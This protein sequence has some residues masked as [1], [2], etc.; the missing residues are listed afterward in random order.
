VTKRDNHHLSQRDFIKI[1]TAFIG[2]FITTL[3]DIPIIGY[4]IAPAIR[5]EE[6]GVFDKRGFVVSGP[7]PRP[8]DVF[9]TKIENG[10]L[11]ILLPAKNAWSER[12]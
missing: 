9:E 10:E 6:N 2:G 7:P 3:A 11:S 4:L 1:V 12:P 5:K 8:L